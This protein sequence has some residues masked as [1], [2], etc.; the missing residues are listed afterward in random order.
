MV[1]FV[2]V[3]VWLAAHGGFY[4]DDLRFIARAGAQQWWSPSYLF[5]DQD[6]HLMPG[7]FLVAGLST[8]AAPLSWVIPATTLVVLAALA[9]AAVWRMLTILLRA[10][11]REPGWAGPMSLAAFLFT[12]LAVPASL[13]W[14]AALNALPLQAALAWVIGDAV[15]MA[16][17]TVDR[18]RLVI[19]AVLVYLMGLA[20]F[21]KSM[22]I[23]F[24]AAAVVVVS[25]ATVGVSVRTALRRTATLWGSLIA[26][27][28]VWLGIYWAVAGPGAG[29]HTAAQTWTLWWRTVER[30]LIPSLVGGPWRWERWVPSPPFAQPAGW[31]IA[32]GWVIL[33]AAV[34]WLLVR[35]VHGWTLPVLL[36]GYLVVSQVPPL[37]FR[38][39]ADTAPELAQTM[40][41][42]PDVAVLLAAL[43]AVASAG[44]SRSVGRGFGRVPR[45]AV[46]G[47]MCCLVVSG[48]VSTIGFARSWDRNPTADYL[49]TARTS[50]ADADVPRI[51]DQPLP[52]EV[53]LPVAYPD[54]QAGR[55]FAA[56]DRRPHIGDWADAPLRVL[57]TRGHLAPGT[58]T[59][60][61]TF[62]AGQGTC[63]RPEVTTPTT[64]ALSGPLLRWRWTVEIPYCATI[65]GRMDVGLTSS[66]TVSVPVR[67]GLHVVYVQMDGEGIDLRIHPVTA[68][69]ALHLGGGTVGEVAQASLVP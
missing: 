20:F 17:G 61:R 55:V 25:A 39:S 22:V 5:A 51:L 34:G 9:A 49:S 31:M 40:R 59:P 11:G 3:R 21:E 2:V 8:R 66:R 1:C 62:G 53:L 69:L 58:V 28:V 18:R 24:A 16:G 26:V 38:S 6:G 33:A 63:D 67:P 50:L 45:A 64:V 41:Y 60:A 48:L 19:R 32:A 27:T 68:G 47:L 44:R 13:W 4:W 54:N 52:L 65:A 43:I 15:L 14:S 37:W 7:A 56:L 36:V 57:D 46:T 29:E 30:G 10:G 23:P 12:P 35:R 42:L